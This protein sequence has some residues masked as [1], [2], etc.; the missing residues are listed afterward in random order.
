MPAVKRII[1]TWQ[2]ADKS[3]CDFAEHALISDGSLAN[4]A[5]NCSDLSPQSLLL[6]PSLTRF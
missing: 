6:M 5:M 1:P 2:Q 3:I 4:A